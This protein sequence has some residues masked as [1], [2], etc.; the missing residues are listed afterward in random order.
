MEKKLAELSSKRDHRTL[1]TWTS[2]YAEH[3][4]PYIEEKSQKDSPHRKAIDAARAWVRSEIS[5][6]SVRSAA[7]AAYTAASDANYSATAAA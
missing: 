2:D 5:I 4:L 6:G 7:F 1:V 3:V